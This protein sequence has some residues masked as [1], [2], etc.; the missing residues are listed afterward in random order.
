MHRPRHA[1]LVAGLLLAACAR[2]QAPAPVAAAGV[3]QA[4]A[5]PTQPGAAQPDLVATAAD[6]TLLLSWISNVPGRRKA[7]QFAAFGGDGRWQSAPRTIAVGHSLLADWADTPHIA[8]TPDGALWVHWLQKTGAGEAA[9]IMLSRSVDGG[10]NWSAPA[11]VNAQDPTAEHGFVALWPATQDTLGVAWLD[12]A[13]GGEAAPEADADAA[14]DAG[15]SLH[16]ARFDRLLARS[17]AAR[18][19]VRACDCCQTAAARTTRGALLAYRDRSADDIRDIAVTRFDGKAWSA[20]TLV[21]AD[22]WKMPACPVNG[23]AL[24]ARGDA[25]VVAWYTAAGGTPSVQLAR[26]DDAGAHFAAPVAVDRGEAVQGRVAVALDAAQAW[27]LWVREDAGGQSLQLA[28]YAPDLSRR[29]AQVEV[30]KL[31]GRGTATGLP[32]LALRADGAWIVWT[33][34]EGGAPLLRGA[35][36][37]P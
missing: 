13:P 7:L 11:Q 30:A 37:A 33:D 19:D 36:V 4:W 22:G 2:E 29:L 21:H 8:A 31:Q 14:V 34:I 1:V 20:P 3:P 24:A 18:I 5:L 26:S 15:T 6:G 9:N 17:D 25:V 27:V 32:Q 35:H 28:R 16:A 23:P 12:G 10:F